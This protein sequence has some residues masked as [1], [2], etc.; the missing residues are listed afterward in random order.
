M[1]TSEILLHYVSYGLVAY[2]AV[3]CDGLTGDKRL[4]ASPADC[5]DDKVPVDTECR[6]SCIGDGFLLV[7]NDTRTCLYDG[8]A[9]SWEP[10]QSPSCVGK[11]SCKTFFVL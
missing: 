8:D 6:L 11:H 2:T 1:F 3:Y 7:G 4:D 10:Q 9:A 5:R